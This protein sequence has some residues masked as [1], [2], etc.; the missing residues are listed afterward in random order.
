MDRLG[1]PGAGLE[2]LGSAWTDFQKAWEMLEEASR[3]FERLR[4]AVEKW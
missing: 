4:E 1:E 2:R 3:G